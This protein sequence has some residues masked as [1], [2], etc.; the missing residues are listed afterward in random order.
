MIGTD[1]NPALSV[2]PASGSELKPEFQGNHRMSIPHRNAY[3]AGVPLLAQNDA[4]PDTNDTAVSG[5]VTGS[6]MERDG[7]TGVAVPS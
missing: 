3:L 2:N 6:A 5:S 1:R 7:Q 4:L